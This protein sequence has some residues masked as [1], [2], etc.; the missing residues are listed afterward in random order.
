[1]FG[2]LTFVS[3]ALF[4]ACVPL[5]GC[6]P[7][8][9]PPPKVA[10]IAGGDGADVYDDAARAGLDAC[11]RESGAVIAVLAPKAPGEYEQQ[12]VLAATQNDDAVIALGYPMARDLAQVARR[13]QAT[14]FALVDAVVDEPNVDSITFKEHEGAFLAGAL[15]AL[16][17]KT[18]RIA[19][20]GGA[21]VPLLR[22]SEA[23][24][25]AGAR[26][27]DPRVR[28]AVRYLSSFTD[29][30]A[31]QQ[32]AAT[33]FDQGSD[34]VFAVA[35]SAGLGAIEAAKARADLF[36]IGADTDQD[37]LAPGKVLTSVVKRVDRAAQRVCT[38]AVA[39]KPMSGHLVLGLAEDGIGL[40]EFRYTKDVI[41]ASRI[42]RLDRIRQAVVAG[43][44][45][46]PATRDELA[47]FRPVAIP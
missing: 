28:V 8:A 35:G 44:L 36:V 10:L 42:A 12:L 17:S 23:G 2:R 38:E 9:A 14:Q 46:V 11:K 37:A 31:A 16:V 29:R 18:H 43:R 45:A 25:V 15:A 24:F 26:E 47:R 33:L 6:H 21:D 19:F 27:V 30:A 3:C 5:A 41:G 39:Q 34:V 32:L 40:T 20:I 13:F 1:M 22:R 4:V 7:G